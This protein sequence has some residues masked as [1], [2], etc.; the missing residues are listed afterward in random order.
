[1]HIYFICIRTYGQVRFST[2]KYTSLLRENYSFFL[3]NKYN[4]RAHKS[5]YYKMRRIHSRRCES[6]CNDAINREDNIVSGKKR[7]QPFICPV[8][9]RLPD[10]L[11]LLPSWAS[12]TH[13]EAHI[14]V[15][16]RVR[17]GASSL[18]ISNLFLLLLLS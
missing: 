3:I 10:A 14:Y 4:K 15:Y 13:A 7:S 18:T 8:S 12:R 2:N 16:V 9:S 5:K 11:G 6:P 1:M 17:T